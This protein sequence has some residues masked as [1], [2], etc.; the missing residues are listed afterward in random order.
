MAQQERAIRTRYTVLEAAAVVFA[1]NGY[2]ASTI[3]EIMSLAGVTKGALY[4]HFSG[5][6]ALAHAVLQ[7]AVIIKPEN[8]VKMQAIVDLGLLLAYRL[9]REPLLQGAARLAADQNARPFF[10]GPWPQWRD[11]IA[12]LLTEG[13]C[14]GE[15]FEHIDPLETANVLVGA[16]TGLQL[17][18]T[19]VDRP[20]SLLLLASDLYRLVLPGIAVPGVLRVLSTDPDRAHHVFDVLGRPSWGLPVTFDSVPGASFPALSGQVDASVP[21]SKR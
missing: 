3:S 15:V 13:R 12:N 14:Q 18:S 20:D 9:P 1:S 4:F 2:E 11:V 7:H 10:G 16:F 17:V 19:T 21:P 6:E 8:P 5:K